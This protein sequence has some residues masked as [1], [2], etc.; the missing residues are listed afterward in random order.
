MS[1]SLPERV[2]LKGPNFIR[3]VFERGVGVEGFISFGIGNPAPEAIPVE[4]IERAFD[5]VV[6][7]NPMSL[8]QY[9]PMQG[10]AHLAELTLERL[11]Q[12]HKMNSE[13]QGLIISNG[14]G[15][16]LGL[17][18]ITVLEPGD[19]V[20]MDEF[21]FT[22]A[23]NSVRN[24]G[25]KA[26]GIKTDE[27]IPNFQNPTGITMP[28]ER[29]KEI[30]AIASKYDLFIY[31]DDP[32]GEIRFAGEYIPTFKSFDIEDRVLYAGSYSKTLSAGLRV[33]FLFGPAKVIEAIQALKNNTAGQMPLVTQK[34]VAKVLETIDYDAHL[35]NVRKVYKMK[36]EALL[37]AFEKYASSKVHLTQPTG[38]MFAWMTMPEDVDCD[39]FFETCMDRNVGIIKCGAFAA[40]G[41]GE[42]HAFRL[43]YTVPT[44][45]EITKGMEILGG[46]TKE[47]CGE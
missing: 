22:S 15:Q 38:G 23:I 9:G 12:T 25:G 32:Y 14:A 34:V 11:V 40:D 17:V 46:L 26:I 6:H 8:L 35:D 3:E 18:P 29:R 19:E 30:Y 36:C 10:D 21:T 13:G 28:L 42:G 47:F 43:S 20:Y 2:T 16:L 1:F 39:V 24:M 37:N 5:E 44:V 27:L 41:A 7:S 4:V 31:E 33:G 45:E